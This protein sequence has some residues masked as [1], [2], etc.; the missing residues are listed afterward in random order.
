MASKKTYRI[1][2]QSTHPADNGKW[3]LFGVWWGL[4]KGVTDGIVMAIDAVYGSEDKYRAVCDQ[5]GSIYRVFGGRKNPSIT[6]R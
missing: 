3:S 4:P 5:D 1:E 2:R 6:G